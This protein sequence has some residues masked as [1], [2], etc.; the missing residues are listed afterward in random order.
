MLAVMLFSFGNQARSAGFNMSSIGNVDTGGRQ[1][2]HWWYTNGSPTLRGE[3]SPGSEITVSVDGSE[4]GISADSAGDW[5]FVLPSPLADGDHQLVI[6]NSG[7]EI[8]FVLT[9]GS[10]NVDWGAVEAGGGETLPTVGT[11]WPTLVILAAG[12][13]MM[14]FGKRFLAYLRI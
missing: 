14:I 1:I 12:L 11:V 2:S 13:V 8:R 3:A 7:S 5:V 10:G 4:Y 6:A 9:I